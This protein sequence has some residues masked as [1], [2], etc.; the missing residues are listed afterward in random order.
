MDGDQIMAGVY[1]SVLVVLVWSGTR[2]VDE[3]RFRRWQERFFTAVPDELR[4]ETVRCLRRNRSLR[5][6]AVAGGLLVGGLPA[7]VNLVAPERSSYFANPGTRHA[8]LMAAALGALLAETTVV[9]RPAGPRRAALV[10]R[11]VGDYIEPGWA[12]ATIVLATLAVLAA[13]VGALGDAPDSGWWWLHA[14]GALLAVTAVGH[15]LR[16]LRDRA[17]TSPDGPRRDLDESLRAESAHH[18]VGA[19]IALAA[20]SAAGALWLLFDPVELVGLLG[21]AVALASL[22]CWWTL[23]RNAPWSVKARRLAAT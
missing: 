6:M 11:R 8:W 9:S 20:A 1:T 17:I 23:A 12:W 14:A 3:T 19:S 10:R 7:Y 16:D 4:G 15:G 2:A 21:E 22:G 13:V 5:T 18:L